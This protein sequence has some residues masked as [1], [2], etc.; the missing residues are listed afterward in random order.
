MITSTNLGTPVAVATARSLAVPGTVEQS[1]STTPKPAPEYSNAQ[2]LDDLRYLSDDCMDQSTRDYF[3]G[4]L[5]QF[6]ELL[7]GFGVRS[8]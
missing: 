5:R 7:I 8:V 6:A 2:Y 4:Q 1:G 3:S